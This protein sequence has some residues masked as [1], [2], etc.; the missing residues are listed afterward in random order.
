M[1]VNS[2]I[3]I[4]ESYLK[5]KINNDLCEDGYVVTK[6]FAAIVDGATSSNELYI[7][8]ETTGKFIK[9]QIIDIITTIDSQ[10][11]AEECIRFINQSL[12]NK[13]QEYGILETIKKD[14]SKIPSASAVIYSKE[15]HEIWFY[16]DCQAFVNNQMIK[17]EKLVDKLTSYVRKW[18]IETHLSS[19]YSEDLLRK[20]DKG[21]EAILPLL[22]TQHL[23]HGD[24]S[25]EFGYSNING[26]YF[27]FKHAKIIKL[28]KEDREIILSSD[29][30]PLLFNNLENTEDY[31]EECLKEDPLCY[32]KITSTKGV[33]EGQISFDDR[34]YLKIKL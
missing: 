16:G 18:V 8:G 5:G 6:D 28:Q 12:M 31:L 34:C 14:E 15:K 27:N 1:L 9:D 4:V 23:F 33:Q 13:Y 20:Y 25:S 2:D 26:F 17:N 30:Y 21:R 10:S 7:N 29:G 32:K 24:D 3:T 11:N 19:G 22:N